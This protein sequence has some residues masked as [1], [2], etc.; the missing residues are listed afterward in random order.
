MFLIHHQLE[1]DSYLDAVHGYF[2]FAF[3]EFASSFTTKVFEMVQPC[4]DMSKSDDMFRGVSGDVVSCEK[5]FGVVL[6]LD[7]I[8]TQDGGPLQEKS[9][10]AVKINPICDHNVLVSIEKDRISYDISDFL[11]L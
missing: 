2:F 10:L 11:Q 5:L 7:D 3:G 9:L 6:D 4:A 8:R 1:L